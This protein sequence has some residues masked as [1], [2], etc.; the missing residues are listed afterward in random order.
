MEEKF[1]P[2]GIVDSIFYCNADKHKHKDCATELNDGYFEKDPDT[3]IVGTGIKNYHINGGYVYN[4]IE[5]QHQTHTLRLL[6][7]CQY[8]TYSPHYRSTNNNYHIL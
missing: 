3:T 6:S 7:N 8:Q 5:N 2:F 4:D 1:I